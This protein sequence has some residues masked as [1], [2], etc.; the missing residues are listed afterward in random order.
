MVYLLLAEGFEE[1]EA[2]APIDILRRAGVNVETVGITGKSVTGSHGITFEADILP[3]QACESMDM[4]ILPGGMP[5]TD[6]LDRSPDMS[7]LLDRALASGAYIAAICAAPKIL[8]E[9]GLLAGKRAV[10]YPGYEEMLSGAEIVH[11]SV[12]TDGRFITAR[13]AGVALDFAFELTS[14]LTSPEKSASIKSS[15]MSRS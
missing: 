14:L 4:L 10:C 15:M 1:I 9:R 11:D 5:G 3:A 12:V 6:N 13:G 2:L 7:I 8:G